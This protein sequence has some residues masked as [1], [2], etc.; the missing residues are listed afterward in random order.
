MTQMAC[1]G[2]SNG[3]AAKYSQ[4]TDCAPSNTWSRPGILA[5]TCFCPWVLLFLALKPFDERYQ[6]AWLWQLYHSFANASIPLQTTLNSSLFSNLTSDSSFLLSK[7]VGLASKR[8][9]LKE[10]SLFSKSRTHLAET[11][12][13]VIRY[14]HGTRS[15]LEQSIRLPIAAFCMTSSGRLSSTV[16]LISHAVIKLWLNT[17]VLWCG[18]IFEY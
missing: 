14:D 5:F 6:S 9:Y 16:I 12:L 18:G 13:E 3:V 11:E 10:S 15:D 8:N 17:L 2:D 7:I 4:S 1:S